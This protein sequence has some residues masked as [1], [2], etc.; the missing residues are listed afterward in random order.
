MR[1][2]SKYGK[3][4]NKSLALSSLTI[5]IPWEG[6]TTKTPKEWPFSLLSVLMQ[7]NLKVNHTWT[8]YWVFQSQL[9]NHVDVLSQILLELNGKRIYKR[10]GI[11]SNNNS[12]CTV[13]HDLKVFWCICK[14]LKRFV[15]T[16]GRGKLKFIVILS[17][18]WSRRQTKEKST[19]T[20]KHILEA[21]SSSH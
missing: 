10:R 7:V 11:H 3:L 20:T 18:Y 4:T 6:W 16:R 21:T 2:L 5:D 19:S 14:Q 17:S 13:G 12:L 15:Y 1:R 8:W 9:L